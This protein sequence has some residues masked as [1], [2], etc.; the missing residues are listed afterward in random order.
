MALTYAIHNAGVTVRQVLEY[1]EDVIRRDV[2]VGLA[3]ETL[4]TSLLEMELRRIARE[5]IS[6][7]PE[8]RRMMRSLKRSIAQ[9]R[10]A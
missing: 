7:A 4:K 9:R 3:T 2:E 6:K 1:I 10:D 8:A 5:S